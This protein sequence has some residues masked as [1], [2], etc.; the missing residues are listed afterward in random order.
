VPLFVRRRF[1]TEIAH[2]VELDPIIGQLGEADLCPL[3]DRRRMDIDDFTQLLRERLQLFGR[4]AVADV[5][6]GTE[7]PV[8]ARAI[9]V[10]QRIGQPAV[11]QHDHRV[12]QRADARRADADMLHGALHVAD[13]DRIAI[14]E[15]PV[16]QQDGGAE[17]VRQCLFRCERDREAADTET[18]QHASHRN[19]HRLR[20]GERHTHD[21]Q[22][23]QH[24]RR[25]RDHDVVHGSR[26]R[27]CR[28]VKPRC[29]RVEQRQA[30]PGNARH[31]DHAHR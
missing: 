10:D 9:V 31:R 21:E 14:S 15:R 16:G 6:P 20:R 17:Q 23:L 29:D 1:G 4:R 13:G 26:G 11:W 30:G 7:Q 18:R 27:P 28:P 19:I 2:Q 5:E 24:A 12:I 22:Q 25:Q 3:L 8:A